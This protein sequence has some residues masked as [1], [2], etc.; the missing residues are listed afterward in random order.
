MGFGHWSFGF[1]KMYIVGIDENGLGPRLG[2]L[3]ATGSIFEVEGA[4]YP[5]KFWDDASI[6]GLIVNDSK[7]VFSQRDKARGERSVLNYYYYL[8]NQH[9]DSARF[10]FNSICITC[11]LVKKGEPAPDFLKDPIPN[12]QRPLPQ[13][14]ICHQ[15]PSFPWRKMS[16]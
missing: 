9:P 2:P 8:F 11:S 4:Y 13:M 10:I 12:F 3:V 15:C 6:P 5:A 1:F 7:K 16:G 14:S